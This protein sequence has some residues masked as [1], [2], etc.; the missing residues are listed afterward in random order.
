MAIM[1]SSRAQLVVVC[2]FSSALFTNTALPNHHSLHPTLRNAPLTE[3]GLRGAGATRIGLK[4]R[5]GKDMEEDGEPISEKTEEGGSSLLENEYLM[6]DIP[7]D[8]AMLSS[9]PS[10]AFRSASNETDD[11]ALQDAN[12]RSWGHPYASHTVDGVTPSVLSN[13]FMNKTFGDDGAD[14]SD[15]EAATRKEGKRKR[16]ALGIE[17]EPNGPLDAALLEAIK[18]GN[19]DKTRELILQGA[20]PNVHDRDAAELYGVHYAAMQGHEAVLETLLALGAQLNVSAGTGDG[21]LHYAAEGGQVAMIRKLVESMGVGVE[22]E[23]FGDTTP[24]FSAVEQGKV[25]ALQALIELGANVNH[26]DAWSTTALH[27]ACS[28]G[29]ADMVDILVKNRADIEA[30]D[31]GGRTPLQVAAEHGED[32]CCEVL[33][34]AGADPEVCAEN[35]F[36]ALG[37]AQWRARKSTIHLLQ[38]AMG[39]AGAEEAMSEEEA[40]EVR[41]SD[42]MVEGSKEWALERVKEISRERAG[43][44]GGRQV[45]VQAGKRKGLTLL[46]DLAGRIVKRSLDKG[47]AIGRPSNAGTCHLRNK[48]CRAQD[49]TRTAYYGHPDDGLRRFCREHRREGDVDLKEKAMP[50]PQWGGAL[51]MPWNV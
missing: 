7:S 43:E 20:D 10:D 21:V 30:D 38:N 29:R 44:A 14:Y 51:P 11:D 5:G 18:E 6:S 3:S 24:L 40:Q 16:D 15:V 34:A 48:Q 47:P 25:H 4:L 13:N 31:W 23:G 39:L 17:Q 22:T 26:S 8:E 50:T 12:E 42:S 27:F 41:R 46:T 9:M 19:P 33:L 45:V 37:W 2:L 49:C 32:T 35:G 1:F 36:N 28:L